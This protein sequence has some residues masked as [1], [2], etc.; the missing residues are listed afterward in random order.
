MPR[1]SHND[2]KFVERKFFQLLRLA[3]GSSMEVPQI[4]KEEWSAIYALA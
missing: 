2:K 4:A 3:I 1:F